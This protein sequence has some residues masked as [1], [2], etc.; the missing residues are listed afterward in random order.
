GGNTDDWNQQFP[1]ARIFR[2]DPVTETWPYVNYNGKSKVGQNLGNSELIIRHQV[3]TTDHGVTRTF[4]FSN[5]SAN[6]PDAPWHQPRY[7]L[8]F[9]YHPDAA[10]IYY[11]PNSRHAYLYG[12]KGTMPFPVMGRP[13]NVTATQTGSYVKLDWIGANIEG[14]DSFCVYRSTTPGLAD[15]E[16]IAQNITSRTYTDTTAL[17]DETYYYAVTVVDTNSR[18]SSYSE[19]ATIVLTPEQLSALLQWLADNGLTEINGDPDGDKI[20]NLVEFLLGSNPTDYTDKTNM[21]S[22]GASSGQLEFRHPV[23]KDANSGVTYVVETTTDLSSGIWTNSGVVTVTEPL[24]STFDTA[25]SVVSTTGK[26]QVFMRLR[27]V[28]QQ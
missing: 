21:P 12:A 16:L 27:V 24:D 7:N 14:F 9:R 20:P 19:P 2:W 15:Y 25:T 11:N 17:P 26:S 10:L 22:Y 6:Y 18:Q 23:R 4:L 28:E 8:S 13:L 5:P 1:K 3:R